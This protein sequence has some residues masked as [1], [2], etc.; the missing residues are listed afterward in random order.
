MPTGPLAIEVHIIDVKDSRVAL[1]F[2][3]LLT[4]ETESIFATAVVDIVNK[5]VEGEGQIND[6]RGKFDDPTVEA[7]RKKLEAAIMA[8]SL[9]DLERELGGLT[10]RETG[11]LSAPK[12]TQDDLD[13]YDARDDIPP[14]ELVQLEKKEYRRFKNSG[15]NLLEWR[16]MKRGRQGHIL[17]GGGTVWRG[18][19]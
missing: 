15:K 14:W 4:P 8:S 7:E 19:A 6:L 5:L 17:L 16:R 13:A 12:L 18:D 11:K 9:G 3:A 1:A 2:D 10:Q